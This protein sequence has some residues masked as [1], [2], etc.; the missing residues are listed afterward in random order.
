MN[1]FN[2]T[3]LLEESPI[4][5]TTLGDYAPREVGLLEH[6]LEFNLDLQESYV[7]SSRKY[8]RALL[9][10]SDPDVLNENVIGSIIEFI[11]SIVEGILDFFKGLFGGSS[12]SSSSSS[13]TSGTSKV[14]SKEVAIKE[15]KKSRDKIDGFNK[16]Y[17]AINT[18]I[19]KKRNSINGSITVKKWAYRTNP[20]KLLAVSDMFPAGTSGPD[21]VNKCF[22]GLQKALDDLISKSITTEEANKTFNETRDIIKRCTKS[23]GDAAR[24]KGVGYIEVTEEDVAVTDFLVHGVNFFH[25]NE[26]QTLMKTQFNETLPPEFAELVNNMNNLI[27]DLEKAYGDS[28][29]NV[30]SIRECITALGAYVMT[31]ENTYSKCLMNLYRAVNAEIDQFTRIA[32]KYVG[33]DLSDSKPK[34]ESVFDQFDDEL[35]L[36]IYEYKQ[37]IQWNE[38]RQIVNEAEILASEGTAREKMS[39]LMAL[40]EAIAATVRNSWNNFITKVKNIFAKVSE[41][42]ASLGTTKRYLDKYKKIILGQNFVNETYNTRDIIKAI[43]R[44]LNYGVPRF[45]YVRMK[46]YLDDPIKFFERVIKPT[47]GTVDTSVGGITKPSNVQEVGTYCNDYFLGPKRDIT[48][49][50]F[51]KYIKDI[52][53]YMYD[54]N[55]IKKRINKDIA[56]IEKNCKDMLKNA[57]ITT[58]DDKKDGISPNGDPKKDN[59]VMQGVSN[60]VDQF[61]NASAYYSAIYDT[62]LTEEVIHELEKVGGQTGTAD[63]ANTGNAAPATDATGTVAANMNNVGPG[64]D[65]VDEKNAKSLG[66]ADKN[67]AQTHLR[68]YSEV[69]CMVLRAKLTAVQFTHKE[70]DTLLRN[71]VKHYINS[72]TTARETNATNQTIG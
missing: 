72:D 31:L 67:S 65:K 28:N 57:G 26:V 45:D 18:N 10:Q 7:E 50:E 9:E 8:Y 71:H 4:E 59:E 16:S 39:K 5:Y 70:F 1:T 66:K 30:P 3:L 54:Y 62:V 24:V 32:G 11:K 37:S 51:Q 23:T 22:S 21:T 36:A 34:D 13:S 40:D 60:Q 61:M 49:A 64:R 12:S 38:F 29:L 14:S 47:M 55:K 6:M 2:P 43:N 19:E 69:S 44:I 20:P 27:K 17:N 15:M 53:D 46:P 41:A 48:T 33:I 58:V 68:N 25:S 52:Y 63:N 56:D 35:T 42:V